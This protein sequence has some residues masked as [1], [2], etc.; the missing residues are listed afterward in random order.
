MSCTCK[1]GNCCCHDTNWSCTC[2]QYIFTKHIIRQRCMCCI[3]KRIKN[4]IH[5][6]RYIRIARPYIRCRDYEIFCK[7]SVSVHADTFGILAVLFV[8]FQTVTTFTTCNMSFSGYQVTDLES[9]HTR[10]Y[11]YNFTYIFMTCSKS[12]RNC[13]LCPV[14]PLINMY[15][16][17]TDCCLVDLNLHIIRSHFRNRNSLHP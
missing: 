5:L 17:S 1:F 7:C 14:I 6:F 10:S 2:N 3:T 15:V 12:D 8:S 4:C 16:C 13:M 11:F 9:F